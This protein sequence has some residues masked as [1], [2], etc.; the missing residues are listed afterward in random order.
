MDDIV[1]Q[2]MHK[3]P[4]VPNCYHWLG[5]D[6]RGNWYMRDDAV[7][8]KGLFDSGASGAKGS[9]LTHAKLIGFIE[10]NY[11]HDASGQ[12]YFQNGPQRVYVAL[13]VTPWI[14]RV[15]AEG[16]LHTHT[17]Q[18]AEYKAC[19]V[20]E[21]GKLYMDTSI[22]LGLVHTQDVLHASH[23]IESG[24][25]VPAEIDSTQ[26]PQRFQFVKNPSANH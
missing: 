14:L 9:L 5:L 7:Q 2:A 20:D 10:R 13:E 24:T 15:D 3:W 26:L 17:T 8:A 25:W 6:A 22:G 12:W 11:A 23:F 21:A 19:F 1:L 4:N 18:P 16:R